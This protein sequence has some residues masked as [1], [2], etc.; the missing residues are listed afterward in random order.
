MREVISREPVSSRLTRAGEF[1]ERMRMTEVATF[2][3]SECRNVKDPACR[4][5]ISTAAPVCACL[6]NNFA[7]YC[8]WPVYAGSGP[9]RPPQFFLPV[10]GTNR[11]QP[12]TL[13][14]SERAPV[15][16]KLETR[17]AVRTPGDVNDGAG[18]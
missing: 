18:E 8:K 5:R 9:P 13:G 1:G 17:A 14:K 12:F 15:S 16:R 2:P 11:P 3:R 7:S 6:Q 4:K 10:I